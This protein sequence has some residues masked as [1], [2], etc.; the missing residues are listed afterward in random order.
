MDPFEQNRELLDAFRSGDSQAMRQVFDACVH[1]VTLLIRLGYQLAETHGR[2]S[3]VLDQEVERDLVQEVFARAFS[4]KARNSY[5]GI[6]PYHP[7][8]LQIARHVLADHWRRHIREQPMGLVLEQLEQEADE[9]PAVDELLQGIELATA[10]RQF[11]AALQPG[12][13]ELVRLRFEQGVGQRE[14][15]KVLKMSRW[16]LRRLEGSIR[17][18]L[19]A[20]LQGKDLL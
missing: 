17:K 8:V 20:Y 19:G 14:A 15:S 18:R 2:V 16:R 11:V 6:R 5:D 7:F 10:T 12:E 13:Q 9:D 1:R 4:E 3:A